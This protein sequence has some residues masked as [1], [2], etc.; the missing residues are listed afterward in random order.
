M[1]LMIWEVSLMLKEILRTGGLRL[2]KKFKKKARPMLISSTSM[3]HCLEF[4]YK[5]NSHL[6]K[7]S[8][9]WEVLQLH[10]MAF[11]SFIRR[12]GNPD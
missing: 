10:L 3:S 8:A 9:T 4:L 11:N 2:I 12:M 5:V 1:A 6:A 7:I